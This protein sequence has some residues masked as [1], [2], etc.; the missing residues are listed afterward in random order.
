[1][2]YFSSIPGYWDISVR[3]HVPHSPIKQINFKN[4]TCS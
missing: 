3:V 2:A 1:M 4:G